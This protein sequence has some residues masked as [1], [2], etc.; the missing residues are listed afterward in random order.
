MIKKWLIL[1]DFDYR[2]RRLNSR[3]R[4][5]G[6]YRREEREMVSLSIPI[7]VKQP[8]FYHLCTTEPE[9]SIL[10]VNINAE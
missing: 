10:F 2:D 8:G 3:T 5:A 9:R 1:E 6:R 4:R 7:M